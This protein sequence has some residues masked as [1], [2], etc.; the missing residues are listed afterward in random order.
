[1]AAESHAALVADILAHAATAKSSR[2]S[3]RWL[4][5]AAGLLVE[6]GPE[7]ARQEL[8]TA[9]QGAAHA[10][11]H[12]FWADIVAQQLRGLLWMTP[13]VPN[14]AALTRA[15]TAVALAAFK[16]IPGLGP[17]SAKVGNAAVRALAEIG[18][19][20]A[21]GQ[22]AILKTRARFA[23]ALKEI[24]KAF[25]A[26]SAKLGLPREQIEELAVPAYQLD[27]SGKRRE[28]LGDYTAEI[29]VSGADAVLQWSDLK[30]KLLKSV[31]ARVKVEHP[32][33]LQDLKQSHKDIQAMLPTQRDRIDG[34]FVQQASWRC[35]VWRERYA[36]HPLVGTISRRLIWCVDGT[37]AL[38]TDGTLTDVTGQAIR[39]GRTAEV[40]LWHPAG[41]SIDEV[42]AWRQRLED[43]HITQPF[44]Q[45]H[46]EIYLLTDAERRTQ[47]YSNRFAA[48]VLRQ[49]QF[50]AL[51]AARGWKNRLRLLVDS[52][53]E[54]PYK[55]LPAGGLRAEFWV[56]GLGG[57]YGTDTNGAGVFL[58]V[59]TDQVRFYRLQAA[60]NIA[61]AAGGGYAM[62]APRGD[63]DRMHEPLPLQDVP[64]LVF[65]EIMRDVDLFVGVASVGNDPTWHDGGPEGRFLDY[66]QS[67]SFGELTGSATTRKQVLER[68]IPRLKIAARCS[69]SERFL[70]VRG[71][72]RTYKIHLG[73]GNIL[74]E[75]NDQYLCIVPDARSSGESPDLYL[76]FEGDRTLSIIL[77]KA[78]LLGDDRNIEDATIV[79][80][81]RLL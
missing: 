22:L 71:D 31:P 1:M 19:A 29:I 72:L 79:R 70:V 81:L 58:R 24:E 15:I 2:P 51:C 23:A 64:P 36:E 77:S 33:E 26:L 6:L 52:A 7:V 4:K 35:D 40:T 28:T 27:A 43:L 45:A 18:S 67:V 10:A 42:L 62:Y 20:D 3:A 39:H 63:R 11:A 37:P 8:V 46:R 57:D 34:L 14:D 55:L 41:R 48:H 9:L 59:A 25:A 60:P 16:K 47:S 30:G 68:L 65:S 76:P 5:S 80:Q 73:S 69:F 17:R 74:M 56:E 12:D 78:F 32:D 21:V 75:P 44:K 66:W 13:L 53:Y 49:H 38:L 61:H 50:H 54:P